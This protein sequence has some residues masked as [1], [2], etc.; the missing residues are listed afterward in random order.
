MSR[1]CRSYAASV[2]WSQR[3][4]ARRWDRHKVHGSFNHLDNS[5]SSCG[6][7][8][9]AWVYF[10][11][12]PPYLLSFSPHPLFYPLPFI[13][14]CVILSSL[15]PLLPWPPPL[16]PLPS[17]ETQVHHRAVWPLIS[18]GLWLFQLWVQQPPW[19]LPEGLLLQQWGNEDKADQEPVCHWRPLRQVFTERIQRVPT[20]SW[21]WVYEGVC[22][23]YIKTVLCDN[24][25]LSN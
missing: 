4:C 24:C 7:W 3:S 5:I 9:F 23:A 18:S 1:L 14:Y 11:S 13:F 25:V 2:P 12:S 15:F 20:F 17:P 10:L 8:T 22:T 16:P 19:P 21:E 6:Q